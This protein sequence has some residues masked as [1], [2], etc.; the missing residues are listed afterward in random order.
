MCGFVCQ[1]VENHPINK[2]IISNALN[3]LSHRGPD[4]KHIW[5][6]PRGNVALG[7]CRLSI[8]SPDSGAQPLSN[9]NDTIHAVVNG[10]FYEFEKIRDNLEKK[11][12]TF[13]TGS[14][15]EILLHL[16]EEYGTDCLHHLRGEFAFV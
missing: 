5:L 11:G 15:S 1:F 16:Y 2:N 13:R 14:D 3:V 4:E 6:D 9:E 7:H 8:I 12:H 10:E